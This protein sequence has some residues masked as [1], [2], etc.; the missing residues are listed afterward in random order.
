A[1]ALDEFLTIERH[2]E[3]G[4]WKTARLAPPE[5]RVL[6]GDTLLVEYHNEDQEPGIAAQNREN[7]RRYE[8]REQYRA[9]APGVR[10]TTQQQQE[11][12]WSQKDLRFRLRLSCAGVD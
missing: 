6:S 3:L 8:L 9:A 11:T 10:L 4:A 5:R 1:E 12:K 2:V 7:L